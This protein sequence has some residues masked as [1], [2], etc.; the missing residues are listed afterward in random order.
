MNIRS[1]LDH[2]IINLY[3]VKSLVLKTEDS[4]THKF[5]KIKVKKW[6][7]WQHKN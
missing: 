6:V 3:I 7:R 5:H 2:L 1:Y 4:S